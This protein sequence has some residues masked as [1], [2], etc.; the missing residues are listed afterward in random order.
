MCRLPPISP[1]TDTLF[2]FTTLS[3]SARPTVQ[4]RCGLPQRP[5]WPLSPS[6]AFLFRL[7]PLFSIYCIF[8]VVIATCG[9]FSRK[10][11][12]LGGEQASLDS[13]L[14]FLPTRS[15]EHTSELQSLMRLSYAV[16]S[17]KKKK[18]S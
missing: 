4:E 9:R 3:R 8:L 17:L 12:L 13:S 15:E 11:L 18:Q 16:F 6:P 2:P 1:R 10:R 7:F 14:P 5:T